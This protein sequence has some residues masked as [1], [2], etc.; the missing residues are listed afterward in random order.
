[1]SYETILYEVEDGI[2]TITAN[3]PDKLNALDLVMIEGVEA[4][5][6]TN[7]GTF[8]MQF[9]SQD[10]PNSV[11]NFLWLASSNYYNR[12]DFHRIVQN[13]IIQGGDPEGTGRGE[14]FENSHSRCT[15]P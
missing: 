1:M 14:V 12:T 15:W 2:L 4:V 9:H 10:A 7:Q 6:Q 13:Y 8:T 5:F 3:R 11:S